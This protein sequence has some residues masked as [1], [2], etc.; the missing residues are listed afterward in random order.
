MPTIKAR[1]ITYTQHTEE[2]MVELSAG[3]LHCKVTKA[4]DHGSV[5]L[6]M[7]TSRRGLCLERDEPASLIRWR[8][9]RGV[10]GVALMAG[11]VT[12]SQ[13]DRLIRSMDDA[14]KIVLQGTEHSEKI[15]FR[16]A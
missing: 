13:F 12:A 15:C 10:A 5:L 14:A 11:K 1:P 6:F 3:V 9:L 8:Y 2:Y 16:Q 4:L 7:R